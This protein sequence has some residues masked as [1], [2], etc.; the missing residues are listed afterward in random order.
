MAFR[1]K[2]VQSFRRSAEQIVAKLRAAEKLRGQGLTI[3]MCCK[4]LGV[5]D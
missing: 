2:A 5:S 3:R 1:E 4:R